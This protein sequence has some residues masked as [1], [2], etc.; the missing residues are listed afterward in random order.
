MLGVCTRICW[1][2]LI[3]F[4]VDEKQHIFHENLRAFLSFAF[5]LE[6]E[7]SL[8]VTKWS[9]RNNVDLNISTFTRQI[10]VTLYLAGW[11]DK[12]LNLGIS[13]V[14]QSTRNAVSRLLRD[15]DKKCDISPFTRG[16]ETRYLDFYEIRLRDAGETYHPTWKRKENGDCISIALTLFASNINTRKIKAIVDQETITDRRH[17]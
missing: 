9:Q 13:P 3:L 17:Q 10:Q 6:R 1:F 2:I 8:W 14:T 15:K 4:K 12:Y 7:F 5:P 16:Q 11:G